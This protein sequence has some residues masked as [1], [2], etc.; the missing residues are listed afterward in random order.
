MLLPN[1]FTNKILNG[2]SFEVL[3]NIP[4]DFVDVCL[5]SPPYFQ[6]R[7]Y[8]VENQ[9]GQEESETEFMGKLLGI[10]KEVKRVL[11]PTGS[12][13]LNIGDSYANKSLSMIPERLAIK[14]TDE[15]GWLLRNK[16]VWVKMWTDLD[17]SFGNCQ[18]TSS[19]DRFQSSYEPL[20]FL[21]KEKEY[22]S[23]LNAIGLPL[24]KSS[25]I[26][27]FYGFGSK[28][29]NEGNYA[30]AHTNNQI[31]F[32][33]KLKKMYNIN[34]VEEAEKLT[35]ADLQK[36]RDTYCRN[37]P[38]VWEL[39][40]SSFRGNHIATFPKKLCE[41]VIKFACPENGLVLDPFSGSGTTCA[42]A[43]E[44][45]RNYIG[46]E[47]NKDYADSSSKLINEIIV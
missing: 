36:L 45:K 15:Q 3:K 41:T 16:I 39:G 5:T 30:M 35:D 2:D 20:F 47:L 28:K 29:A 10:F 34:T 32:S 8:K 40:I 23:N 11:K 25:I 46:I 27:A 6:H 1:E 38:D 31:A 22:F 24:K 17:D 44:L 7:N 43:K 26:R 12:F 13:W 14:L 19:R 37:L 42:V 4:S 33:E 21:T 9:I 18:P